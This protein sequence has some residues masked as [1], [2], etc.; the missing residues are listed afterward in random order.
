[1]DRAAS[2][3][4]KLS[5]VVVNWHTPKLT[6]DCIRSIYQFKPSCSF[7]VIL[8]NNGYNGLEEEDLRSF[9]NLKIIMTGSNLGFSKANNLGIYNTNGDF[10]LLLNSDTVLLENSF[11]PMLAYMDQNEHVGALGPREVDGEKRYRLSCGAFPTFFS[12]VRRKIWHYRLSINDYSFRDLLDSQHAMVK[13]VDW[14][15]GSCMMLRRKALHETGL[16]DE[17]FFMYFEDIDLC[18]RLARKRWEIHYFPE[19]TLIHLGGG[20][21]R[22]NLMLAMTEYRRSEIYFA[23]KYYGRMGGILMR[24]FLLMKYSAFFLTYT[25]LFLAKKIVP[26]QPENY[27]TYVLLAKKVIA[28]VFSYKTQR[29]NVPQLHSLKAVSGTKP[30]LEP[31]GGFAA[32]TDNV[33][34]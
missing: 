10:I 15:S 13:D 2:K 32:A 1:M 23:H 22:M 19:T 17:N 34:R 9:H 21:A 18:A 20:S 30:S 3:R 11:D 4:L 27:Y 26:G 25:P 33:T 8:V 28:M 16:L 31:R 12:E 29:S 14:V 24:F 6:M 7:E 5:I